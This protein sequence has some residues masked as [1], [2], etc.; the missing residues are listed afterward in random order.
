MSTWV[1]L[2]G[3]VR[4]TRHWGE[5]PQQMQLRFPEAK[6]IA[7][8]LP[9][10][11]RLFQERSPISIKAM[12]EFCSNTLRQRGYP[13]PY[14]VLALSLGAMVAVEWCS[15]AP[16][17]ISA[18]VLI[19]TS[20]RPFSRFY[21]R[22]R[23]ENYLSLLSVAGGRQIA[24]RESLIWRLTTRM[25]GGGRA[26][27]AQ[28]MQYQE[29]YPVSQTNTVRQLLAAMRFRAPR[30]VP[31]VPILVLASERDAL[32]NVQCSKRLAQAWELAIKLH[33]EAGHDLPLDDSTWVLDQLAN[34][35][36]VAENRH[37]TVIIDPQRSDS[38][39]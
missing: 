31:T 30:Q 1:L 22:L 7:F 13:P 3:L 33:P 17:E 26:T 29:E 27:I 32:V 12:A 23:P 5:F 8:D 37:Q 19:N 20:M 28:W 11:G 34:W 4:E 25:Q 14:N 39:R 21:H 15:V 9:G 6:I 16:D 10:N 38:Q 18:C 24:A 35:R 36:P 2:R